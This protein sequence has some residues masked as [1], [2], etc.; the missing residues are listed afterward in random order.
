[1]PGAQLEAKQELEKLQ[2][3]LKEFQTTYDEKLATLTTKESV[4][5]LVDE[6]IGKMDAEFTKSLEKLEV[7]INRMGAEAEEKDATDA[8]KL[9]EIKRIHNEILLTGNVNKSDEE[10]YLKH[11]RENYDMDMLM[12]SE[13]KELSTNVDP[14]GGFLVRPEVS[15][16]IGKKIFESG[17]L[18]QLADSIVVNSSSWEEP[19]D[20]DEPDGGW[21]GE[22]E[23][24]SET[25]TNDINLIQIPVHELH[26]SP[27]LTQKI[28][29]DAGIDVEAWHQSK[30]VEKFGRLEAAA[31][32]NGSGVKK[33]K[34]I[35]Q[36]DSG[37]G[38]DKLEQV[39]LGSASAF[40][41]DGV[42]SLQN[43]L[44]EDF[45]NGASWLSRREN[46]SALRKL[47]AGDGHYLLSLASGL[48]DAFP[49]SLLGKPVN[50]DPNIPAVAGN[51]LALVYGNFKRGYLIV[52]RIGI[53]VLRDPYTT[54]GKVIFYTTKRVGGGVRQFQAIKI[55]K[56]ATNS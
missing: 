6:K 35:L 1:M 41:S 17:V 55:G 51:A 22:T 37:D 15:S 47:K 53:R 11:C 26:A 56:I 3:N 4:D 19:Y 54:K 30:V 10:I 7:S 45:Q 27:Y 46:V 20:N 52:D 5:T 43:A 21:V 24:R 31:F 28:I 49:M 32:V 13:V 12:K 40:T 14:R 29:D 25:D 8:K 34:G 38:F 50:F 44:L 36:Y 48:A 2:S 9:V 33:P 42:I 23:T 18:R 39:N 16:E